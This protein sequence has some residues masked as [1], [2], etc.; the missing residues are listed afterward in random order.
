MVWHRN[1]IGILLQRFLFSFIIMASILTFKGCI[2]DVKSANELKECLV[3]TGIPL[4]FVLIIVL[5]KV[6]RPGLL[7]FIFLSYNGNDVTFV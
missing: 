7:D 5:L 3:H 1:S 6:S 2:S 4:I